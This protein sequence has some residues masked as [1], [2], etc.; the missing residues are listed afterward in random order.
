MDDIRFDYACQASG[1]GTVK[2]TVHRTYRTKVRGQPFVVPAARV[3]VCED[4]GAEH[5]AA[6]EI[7]RWDKLFEEAQAQRRLSAADIRELRDT[8]QLSMEQFAALVGCTRQ[9]LY[10]WERADRKRTQSLMVDL[11]LRL[12]DQS[13]HAGEVHVL[14][15]LRDRANEL[16][17]AVPAPQNVGW[18]PLVLEARRMADGESE[19][20]I[21][22]VDAETKKRVATLTYDLEQSLLVVE[23]DMEPEITRF[24]VEI[25]FE[26]GHSET[27]RSVHVKMRLAILL[28]GR[29]SAKDVV[30]VVIL[31]PS[32]EEGRK[33][34]RQG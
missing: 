27:A 24:D 2:E 9:S 21:V 23:F 1:M 17:M 31:P 30:E 10:H 34:R 3:G 7:A 12:V 28:K 11:M 18:K 14:E 20:T 13:R 22:L 32:A 4:C 25:R 15:F 33:K 6:G 5:F 19:G 16:G 26:D 29:Y 8:L